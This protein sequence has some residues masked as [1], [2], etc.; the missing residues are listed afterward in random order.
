[1]FAQIQRSIQGVIF[2]NYEQ[3]KDLFGK[4]KTQTGLKVFLRLNM[5]TYSIG[6]KTP[7]EDV[8]FTRIQFHPSIPKLSYRIAD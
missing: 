3:V 5:K 1:L 2:N 6:I 4:T 7:K 8:D